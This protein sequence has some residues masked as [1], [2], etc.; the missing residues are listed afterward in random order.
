[1]A[2]F[3]LFGKKE[4]DYE[5]L[6]INDN[7]YDK[8][9]TKAEEKNK[10]ETEEYEPLDRELIEKTYVEERSKGGFEEKKSHVERLCEQMVI[11]SR[12][13]ENAKKEYHAV[14]GYINDMMLI[15]NLEEPVKGNVEYYARRI[16]TLREDKKSMRQHSTKIPDSKYIYMQH[17]EDE[18]K[19]ILKDMHDDE[20]ECQRLKTDLHNIEGEKFALTHEK[21]HT[22]KRLENIRAVAKAGLIIA[23]IIIVILTGIQMV[24][25]S[26]FSIGIYGVII[27]VLLLA[28]V[29]LVLNQKYT[30]ELKLLDIKLNKAVNLL[31]KYKLLYV[32]AK[33]RLDYSYERNGVKSSYELNDLW[34]LYLNVKKEYEAFHMNA[35]NSFK[36]IEGLMMELDKLRLYDSSVWASQVDAIVDSKEM[37]QIRHT[38]NVRRQKL[39]EVMSVNSD[40]ITK[41]KEN[42]QS[43][44]ENN[45]DMSEEIMNILERYEERQQL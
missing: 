29:L 18:I 45:P 31:N 30:A 33:N 8:I 3:G 9:K 32:N 44:A 20:Q 42:I 36:A 17:H 11:C 40:S 39:K 16:I 22:R 1:M 23:A 7:L 43:I 21:K 5:E 4:K 19:D 2:F 13:I 14:N 6:Y 25:D 38:L 26:N 34:R 27:G 35:D 37:T 24:A 41:L 28:A 12:R 15:S 10:K